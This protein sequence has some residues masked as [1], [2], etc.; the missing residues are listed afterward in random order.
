[1]VNPDVPAPLENII[2]TAMGKSPESR[3]DSADDMRADLARFRRGEPTTSVPMAAV[4]VTGSDVTVVNPR[5]D[6]VYDRTTV[7][8]VVSSPTLPVAPRRSAAPFVLALIALLAV[9]AGLGYL[10]AKQLS[11]DGGTKLIAVDNYVGKPVHDAELLIE[12]AGL[13]PDSVTEENDQVPAGQV[14]DQNPA[15]GTK[16]EKGETVHLKV[17]AGKGQVKVPDVSGQSLDDAQSRLSDANLDYRVLQEVSDSVDA[18]KVTRTDPPSGSQVDKG[19]VV[20]LYVSAGKEQVQVPD[21]SGQDPVTAANALGAKDLTVEQ[22]NQPSDTVDDG[23]VIGTN[24]AAGT[25]VYKGSKIQLI[26]SSG[27]EQVRVPNVVGLSKTDATAE[28][29]NAGF[30]VIVR[31]VTSLDPNNAGRVI[32]QSPSSDSKAAKGSAVTISVGKF[33]TGTTTTTTFP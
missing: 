5:M 24:P 25:S 10:L 30:D 4:P 23:K 8:T 27:K 19:T 29:Q 22:V 2:L 12:N 18:G 13:K 7:G 11:G 28:L 31:E 33:A 16:I 3:Y 9:L 15:A 17:S 14:Y 6:T 20:K 32:A 21:V 1:V 26:V